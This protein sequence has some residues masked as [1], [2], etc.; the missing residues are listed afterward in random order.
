MKVAQ[1]IDT[2]S[3]WWKQ[4]LRLGIKPAF[5]CLFAIALSLTFVIN[6]CSL[7]QISALAIAYQYRHTQWHQ[8]L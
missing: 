8:R 7:G 2:L 4:N 3:I 6:A 5:F 1:I